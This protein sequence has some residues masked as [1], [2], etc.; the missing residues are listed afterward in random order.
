MAVVLEREKDVHET[1]RLSNEDKSIRRFLKK[2]SKEFEIRACYEASCS[3]YT[4]QRKM[5]RWGYSC[6]V[7]APSLCLFPESPIYKSETGAKGHKIKNTIFSIYLAK[8]IDP[9]EKNCTNNSLEAM[10]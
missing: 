2:F 9:K 6:E 1:I 3:D 7:I 5:N 10:K 4:S 8:G